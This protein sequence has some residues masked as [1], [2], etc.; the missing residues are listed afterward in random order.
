MAQPAQTLAAAGASG[1]PLL[2]VVDLKKHFPVSG[3]FLGR[4]TA[5]VRAVDGIS[6][7][8]RAG[9]TLGLVGESGSGKTTTGRL[10]LRLIPA[11][12]GRVY[13]DGKDV[14][15]L[16]A[17]ELRRLRR[18]MQIVFQDPY[19]SLN[20]RMT[21]GEIVEEPLAIHGV[22]RG[23]QRQERVVQLLETVGLGAHHL[24]RHPHEFSGGQRQRISIARALALNPRLIVC[25]EAVSALDVSIQSQVINL[26]EDL[27]RRFGL[28]Y[29]FIAHNLSVI[30]HISDRVGVMYLGR[31]VELAPSEEL[32]RRPAHPYTEALLSA[33]PVPDPAVQRER[34][35][36]VLEG[37]VPNP[38]S[39]PTG[40]HFHPRCP[41]AF[42]HCR[43]VE[44]ELRQ[45]VSGQ[46]V[47]CHLHDAAVAPADRARDFG[48]LSSASLAGAE[49][50]P[51]RR[52]LGPA[53][54]G[55]AGSQA[56]PE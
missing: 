51:G 35:R 32:Y 50:Q 9:E 42:A 15:A 46:W 3:G 14:F 17:A 41:Y 29:L 23:R 22:A 38:I 56:A 54:A 27:Q 37:E 39:P 24:R 1:P 11:T 5:W 18:D 6:F 52:P 36:V 44:P 4:T 7:E 53:A 45:V 8:I 40:C 21:V 28:T 48:G 43:E 30:K 16:P 2:R 34:R 10:L 26:F 20:P 19:A 12:G 25:D 49:N 33:I 13:F 31:L 47:A 55:G